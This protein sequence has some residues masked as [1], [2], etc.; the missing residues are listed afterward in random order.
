MKKVVSFIL[1]LTLVLGFMSGCRGV[2]GVLI[3]DAIGG[4]QGDDLIRIRI[5]ATP[6]PHQEILEY[7]MPYLREDGVVL[8]IVPFTEFPL[9][10]PA[11]ADGSL[12][13]NY[14]QHVPFLNMFMEATG[15]D[16]RVLGEIHVEPMG[17]YSSRWNDINDLPYGATVAMP[18]DVANNA[19]ALLLLQENGLVELDPA[20]DPARLTA[21]DIIYN[22]LGLVV[23]TFDAAMLPRVLV[24]DQVDL[25]F[26]NTNHLLAGAPAFNPRYDSLIREGF[27]DNPFANV[28]VTRPEF[29]NHPAM[30]TLLRHLQSERVRAFIL[31]SYYGVE[32]VF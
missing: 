22:P 14:F 32:P 24:D 18:N 12:D 17:A 30:L 29:E 2:E 27:E 7:I 19:R 1:I 9:V 4:N 20:A 3:A 23:M 13:A 6:I 28:L 25:A 31:R 26:V 8:E 16:L 5:G 15:T 11:L 21:D 10:N